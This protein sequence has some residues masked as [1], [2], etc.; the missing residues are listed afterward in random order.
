VQNLE[1]RFADGICA[2]KVFFCSREF[3]FSFVV[4]S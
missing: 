4:N 2:S 1:T 3:D